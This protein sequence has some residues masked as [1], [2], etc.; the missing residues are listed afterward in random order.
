MRNENEMTNFRGKFWALIYLFRK[1]S[2]Y[3]IPADM[4]KR[5]YPCGP[6]DMVSDKSQRM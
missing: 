4:V 3:K 6:L 2:V 1:F 5:T